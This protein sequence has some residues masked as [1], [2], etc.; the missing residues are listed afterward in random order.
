MVRDDRL[1]GVPP[2]YWE[3]PTPW[4]SRVWKGIGIPRATLALCGPELALPRFFA[5]FDGLHKRAKPYQA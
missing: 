3:F 5:C 1:A 4:P 2:D